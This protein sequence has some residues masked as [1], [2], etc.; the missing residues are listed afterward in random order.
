VS[1]R[2]K[3]TSSDDSSQVGGR[4]ATN[5]GHQR[6]NGRLVK[7]K[8]SSMEETETLYMC[9]RTGPQRKPF[10]SSGRDHRKKKE[11]GGQG[12][13]GGTKILMDCTNV[14][15]KQDRSTR[16]KKY[17]KSRKSWV[18]PEFKSDLEIGCPGERG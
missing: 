9:L 18:N 1:K 12:G 15:I 11:W 10:P 7:R 5:K 8:S 4:S 17:S 6:R 3:M 13:I 14:S 2:R 16:V